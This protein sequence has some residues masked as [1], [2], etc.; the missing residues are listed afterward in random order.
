M[1]GGRA[2]ALL[3]APREDARARSGGPEPQLAALL[4]DPQRVGSRSG[5]AG[6]GKRPALRN[7]GIFF[8]PGK[9]SFS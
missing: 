7:E 1:G 2:I 5:F 8:F 4:A 9:K 6:E 3:S